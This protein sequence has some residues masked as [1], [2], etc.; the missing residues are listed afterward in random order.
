MKDETNNGIIWNIIALES[1]KGMG[2]N[3]K[4]NHQELEIINLK[5]EN[6]VMKE[7]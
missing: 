5:K 6:I 7:N 4:V 1:K 2:L 3:G